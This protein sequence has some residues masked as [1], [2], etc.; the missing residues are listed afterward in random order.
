MTAAHVVRHFQ[1]AKAKTASLVCQLHV[2]PFDLERALIDIND[3]LDIATFAI[4]ERDLKTSISEAFDVTTEWPA[5][6]VVKPRAPIQ[7]IGYPENIRIID[8]SDRSAVFQAYGAFSVVEDF[9]EREIVVVYDPKKG[10]G[11]P[12]LPPLGYNM[13]GCSGGPAIIHETRNGLHRWHPVGLVIGG[14]KQGDGAAAEFDII[15]IRRIDCIDPNDGHI[16]VA[17]VG[18]LPPR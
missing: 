10:I 6:D 1:R 16:R 14:P 13:S 11:A 18:W 2:M 7:L 17:D 15:R 4:S 5:E 12:T 3:V 8:P 9:T